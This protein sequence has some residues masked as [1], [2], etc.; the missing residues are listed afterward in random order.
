MR[1]F[2]KDQ[3]QRPLQPK[4]KRKGLVIAA[5]MPLLVNILIKQTQKKNYKSQQCSK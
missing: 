1:R 2:V 4:K 3:L 5:L